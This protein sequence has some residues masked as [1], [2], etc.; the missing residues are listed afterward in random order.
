MRV[1]MHL[2]LQ[3]SPRRLLGGGH[4]ESGARLWTE[5]TQTLQP[6]V[7]VPEKA[8]VARNLQGLDVLEG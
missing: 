2:R 7:S 4:D 8:E 3:G 6:Q 5:P 1:D